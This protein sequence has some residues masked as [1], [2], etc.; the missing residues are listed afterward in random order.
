MTQIS[1]CDVTWIVY[2][3]NCI[4]IVVSYV[5]FVLS[6]VQLCDDISRGYDIIYSAYD[7]TDIVGAM[8][9]K[10]GSDINGEVVMR[11]IQLVQCL[12]QWV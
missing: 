11:K 9:Y 7:V 2:I 4:L 12:N 8:S 5:K 10:S 3:L 1:Y 6:E